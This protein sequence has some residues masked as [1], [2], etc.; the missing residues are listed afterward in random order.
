MTYGKI[1]TFCPVLNEDDFINSV[2]KL[3]LT[4]E[5]LEVAIN[6]IRDIDYSI[7]YREVLFRDAAHGVNQE[8]IMKEV[9]PD[10]ILMP[11]V[12]SRGAMWQETANVKTDT[13]AR[14]LFPI[15]MTGDLDEQMAENMGR[16]RWEICRKIQGVYWNDIRE[17]S[18]TA[19]YCDYLQFYRKNNNL[20]V[21]AKEKVKLALSRSRN[22]YREVFAKEYQN[23][24]KFESKGS[25]RLNKVARDILIQY[26]PFAKDIRQS[27][28]T[29]PVFESAFNKLEINNQKKVQRITAFH[30]KYVAAGGTVNAELKDNLLFYQM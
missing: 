24:L 27:L 11:V 8:P 14:F 12:G 18:L 22:N 20:S 9:L 28:K 26:C 23:W 16:Y 30:D 3:A 17:K 15:F 10:V 25:F 2:E 6:K 21:E 5:K 29:N 13:S 19:E 7:F 1:T 4:S